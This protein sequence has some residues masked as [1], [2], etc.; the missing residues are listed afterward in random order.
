MMM[1]LIC[2]L[3]VVDGLDIIMADRDMDAGY[4]TVHAA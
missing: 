4:N 2:Q 3:F 1:R